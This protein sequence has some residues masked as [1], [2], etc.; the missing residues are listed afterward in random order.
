MGLTKEVT[1][2]ALRHHL[3]AR[4]DHTKGGRIYSLVSAGGETVEMGARTYTNTPKGFLAAMRLHVGRRE[5]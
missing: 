2:Y 1:T 5:A 3:R 4:C